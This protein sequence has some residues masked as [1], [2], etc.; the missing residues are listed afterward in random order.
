MP[1]FK[2]IRRHSVRAAFLAAAL[3]T[4]PAQ[5]EPEFPGAIF[6]AADMKCVPTCTLCHTSNPGTASTWQ[7]KML[8]PTLLQ[9]GLAPGDPDTMNAAFKKYAAMHTA[10]A[11]KIKQGID[12][13]TNADVC[14]PTYGCGAHIAQH[15]PPR[16]STAPLWILGAALVGGLLRRRK[17]ET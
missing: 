11:A 2:S 12:P 14:G 5:A 3:Q 10:E 8:G 17:T 16:D 9:S 1:A 4:A 13:Q 15:A 7:A 6:D